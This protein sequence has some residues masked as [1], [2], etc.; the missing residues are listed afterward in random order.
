MVPLSS[1]FSTIR[2][3]NERKNVTLTKKQT[4]LAEPLG[5]KN[6]NKIGLFVAVT[7]ETNKNKQLTFGKID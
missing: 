7:C 5:E 6:K 2:I 4:S 3:K 1:F